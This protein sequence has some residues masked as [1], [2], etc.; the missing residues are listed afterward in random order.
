[1][2]V[3]ARRTSAVLLVVTVGVLVAYVVYPAMSVFR[4]G[5]QLD[6]L[7]EVFSSWRSSNV[8]ALV[9][10]VA[11]SVYSVAGAGL[12]G[13]ALAYIFFRYDFPLRRVLLAVA[14]LPLALPPL[15]GVLAFLFLYGESGILPRALQ[16]A[17]S[18]EQVPFSFD[19]LWA[20]WL[21][22]VYTM[23]VYFYLFV[24]AALRNVDRSV[25]EASAGLGAHGFTTFVRVILPLLRPA[26]VGAA[27]LVFMISMASFT[28]P[29]LF[30][31]NDHFLTLQIYNYKTNG[32][33]D[34]SAAV[35][36]VLTIICLVFLVLLEL[37]NRSRLRSASKGTGAPARRIATGTTRLVLV[38][39]ATT[40]L[41][42][43]LLPIA[44]IVLISFAMEGSWTLQV[45]PERYTFDN[46]VSLFADPDVLRPILN[47][48]QM[49]LI[50]TAANLVFGVAAAL[51]ITK[52]AVRGRSLLRILTALPFAIPGTVIAVNLIV[53]FNRPSLL[54][55]GN[56]MVGTFWILPIA[57]FVRNVPFIVR[58]A[59]A[60]LEAVDDTLAEASSDLGASRPT[61]FRRVIL[62]LVTPAIVAGTLLTFVNALG[63]FVASVMLY[64]YA[65]R[66]ISVEILAQLRLY[67]FGSAAAYSV[68]LMLMVLAATGVARFANRGRG[69]Y[70][71]AFI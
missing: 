35:S 46:Y 34:L 24:G 15:V 4:T 1:M 2:L 41:V 68:L 16:A 21:V 52:G 38:T 59:T 32:N 49:A 69:T 12:V 47:S 53:A 48:L 7:S 54:T 31:G 63:E 19:G 10:S 64:V 66:P 25:L 40:T 26:L 55:F 44:T 9:N 27:L 20:V 60:A 50:A 17:L 30:A 65:N 5:L 18:L 28:A 22:H 56:V 42:V 58:S 57:Y 6:V 70:G 39:V 3:L 23:Y 37:G 51:T 8:R 61:T 67:D 62:P 14:V 29:L 45:F 11:I 71:E 13:T 33:L 36:T 43:I